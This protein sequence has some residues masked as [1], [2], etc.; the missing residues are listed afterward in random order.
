MLQGL[1]GINEVLGSELAHFDRS[2][3]SVY[4]GILHIVITDFDPKEVYVITW[5]INMATVIYFFQG[6]VDM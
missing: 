6:A 1:F 3:C 2:S 4:G 5:L